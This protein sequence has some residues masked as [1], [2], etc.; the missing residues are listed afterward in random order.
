[1]SDVILNDAEKMDKV[2][3]VSDLLKS[4]QRIQK[5]KQFRVWYAT[6]KS[7]GEA[8]DFVDGTIQRTLNG[9]VEIY[10]GFGMSTTIGYSSIKQIVYID[11]GASYDLSNTIFKHEVKIQDTS[12]F[13]YLYDVK[14]RE[15]LITVTAK[16]KDYNRI[17]IVTG[18]IDSLNSAM[19]CVVV[20]HNEDNS[21]LTTMHFSEIMG[22]QERGGDE[23]DIEFNFIN[24]ND[25]R[26]KK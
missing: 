7:E 15:Q 16:D 17:S 24:S 11:T 14:K 10:T 20:R 22:V 13:K 18:K 23:S 12:I 3:F 21:M 9:S 5:D 6:G 1:M 19:C 8:F 25:W 26:N 2:L 4:F